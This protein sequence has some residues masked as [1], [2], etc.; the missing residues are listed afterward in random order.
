MFISLCLNAEVTSDLTTTQ[1][2]HI[3]SWTKLS[4]FLTL[5]INMA[6]YNY[7]IFFQLWRVI[8]ID[9]YK[10]LLYYDNLRAC[11]KVI[12]AFKINITT[13]SSSMLFSFPYWIS[14]F[15]PLYLTPYHMS[16]YQISNHPG[17]CPLN[18]LQFVR[19]LHHTF[20]Y[21]LTCLLIFSQ[22]K[23]HSSLEMVLCARNLST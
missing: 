17:C 7:Y 22:Y 10:T 15:Y 21:H 23:S 13:F 1:I 19:T 5:A 3:I 6:Q 16:N 9:V 2:I 8:Y 20:W 11:Y 18:T 14:F 12:C 4:V